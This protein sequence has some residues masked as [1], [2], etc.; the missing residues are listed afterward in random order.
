MQTA[1]TK[2]RGAQ[3]LERCFRGMVRTEISRQVY[4]NVLCQQNQLF[5]KERSVYFACQ[6]FDRYSFPGL[7][8]SSPTVHSIYIQS[9]ANVSSFGIVSHTKTPHGLSIPKKLNIPRLEFQSIPSAVVFRVAASHTKRL[10][11]PTLEKI[12]SPKPAPGF[13][14]FPICTVAASL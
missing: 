7:L 5:A 12:H 9:L 3:K 2:A 14:C 1:S 6:L 10:S 8:Y 11:C 4:T 13:I